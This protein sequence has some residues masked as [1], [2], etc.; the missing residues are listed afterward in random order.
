MPATSKLSEGMIS[1]FREC[2]RVEKYEKDIILFLSSPKYLYLIG[3]GLRFV[4]ELLR[5]VPGRLPRR[6]LSPARDEGTQHPA[7]YK[8]S[9]VDSHTIQLSM[10]LVK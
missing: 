5:V 9:Q 1:V 8:P 6:G 4:V 3:F 10:N 7:N 2:E